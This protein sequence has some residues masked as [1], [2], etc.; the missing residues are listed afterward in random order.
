[1]RWMKKSLLDQRWD[2]MNIY[3]GELGWGWWEEESQLGQGTNAISGCKKSLQQYKAR[4]SGSWRA[5]LGWWELRGGVNTMIVVFVGPTIRG[6]H[7]PTASWQHGNR[8]P[9]PGHQTHWTMIPV[10]GLNL[11][12]RRMLGL[13]ETGSNL[14][15]SITSC[16]YW[17]NFLRK[18]NKL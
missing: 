4:V 6:A 14:V 9:F 15:Q 12:S 2:E 8:R 5:P 17:R 1:M 16:C 7:P 18:R 10:R 11:S 13:G 3:C